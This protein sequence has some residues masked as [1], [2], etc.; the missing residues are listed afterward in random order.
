MQFW[1]ATA[2]QREGAFGQADGLDIWLASLLECV[3]HPK[4]PN[5]NLE[6][7][8]G[9]LLEMLELTLLEACHEAFGRTC[10]NHSTSKDSNQRRQDH[11]GEALWRKP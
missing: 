9:R 8:I 4:L 5:F 10:R 7:E 3:F 6:R 11:S 2:R 1:L